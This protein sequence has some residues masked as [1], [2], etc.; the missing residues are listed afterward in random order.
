[1]PS[2]PDTAKRPPPIP[3]AH[4]KTSS[5][6]TRSLAGVPAATFG[7]EPAAAPRAAA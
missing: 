4:G 1:M 2:T 5:A 3:I 6:G 7:D